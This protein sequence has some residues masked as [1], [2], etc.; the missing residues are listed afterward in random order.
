M[1]VEIVNNSQ[2]QISTRFKEENIEDLL[3]EF[4]RD[5]TKLTAQAYRKDLKHFFAFTIKHFG[6]PAFING[7]MLFE[8]IQ[9]VQGPFGNNKL[10]KKK[11]V[12]SKFC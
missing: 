12:C 3:F 7:K 1:N 9:R 2:T 10:S 5:R 8:D 4:L 6:V 11:A